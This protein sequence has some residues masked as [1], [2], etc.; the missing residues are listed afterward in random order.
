MNVDLGLDHQ[1]VM[2]LSDHT[3]VCV[4]L[5]SARHRTTAYVPDRAFANELYNA[6]ITQTFPTPQE[7]LDRLKSAEEAGRSTIKL[8]EISESWQRD[9]D[10]KRIRQI[11]DLATDTKR[12]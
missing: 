7:H 9:I 4:E 8:I 12:R 2:T 3:P 1:N 11:G 10:L 5:E 6:I